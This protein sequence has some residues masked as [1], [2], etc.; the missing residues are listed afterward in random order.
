M[1][2]AGRRPMRRLF[3]LGLVALMLAGAGR[4]RPLPAAQSGP[5]MTTVSDTVYRADGSPAQGSAI[6]TW[7]AFVTA[8]GKAV[9]AGTTNVT[10]G[11]NGA[12]S[13]K[14][15]PNVGANPAGVYYSVVF[16]LGPGEVKTEFWL[17]PATSPANL[18][19]VRTTPG[20]GLATQSVSIRYVNT[21]LASK[22]NDN[23]AVAMHRFWWK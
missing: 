21:A 16:Q 17:V 20:S 2:Y 18:A 10:L 1:F 5:A 6:I 3:Y 15:V 19:A 7:P 22:A 14:L 11:T 9:A 4:A 12:L 23:A 13:A 8:D